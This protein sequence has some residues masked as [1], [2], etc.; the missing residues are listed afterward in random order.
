MF[1]RKSEKDDDV[2]NSMMRYIENEKAGLWKMK[3]WNKGRN[4]IYICLRMKEYKFIPLPSTKQ[5]NRI[6][7]SGSRGVP[8]WCY[9]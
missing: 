2:R 9:K 4:E 5:N 7:K 8:V 6:R 1:R 3:H